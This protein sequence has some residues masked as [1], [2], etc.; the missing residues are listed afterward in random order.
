MTPYIQSA[1]GRPYYPRPLSHPVYSHCVVITARVCTS[2]CR[3][4]SNDW[5]VHFNTPFSLKA[6]PLPPVSDDDGLGRLLRTALY[7]V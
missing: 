1:N 3:R 6:P 2:S 5:C 7:T 4:F